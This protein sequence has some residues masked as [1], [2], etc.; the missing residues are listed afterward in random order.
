MAE[1][2]LIPRIRSVLR[3]RHYSRRTEEAYV[4]WIKR[5]IF[6][7]NKRHPASMGGDE[8]NQ[9][10]TS[11]AVDGGVSA[12]TQGQALSALLF[13]YRYV[14]ED[15][16]PWLDDVVRAHRPFRIPVV[17]TPDE[18]RRLLE[19]LAGVPKLIALLLYGGGLRL[20]EC[21]RLR[22]KDVNFDRHE[23]YVRDPKGRRDRVTT[24]PRAAHQLL[25]EHLL[26]VHQVHQR[27]LSRGYGSVVLPGAL[28]RK[29]P[30]AA[31]DWHWQWVFPARTRWREEPSG[32]ERHH[33]VHETVMQRAIKI[34]ATAANF[35]KRVTCHTLRHSSARARPGHPH[36]P[37]APR[38]PRR[39]HD[40]DLHARSQNR[41]ERSAEPIGRSMTCAVVYVL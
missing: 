14:L 35:D 17:L 30:S 41:S 8:V 27:D 32:I 19:H 16:L 11:L 10:L 29:L 39:H 24:F 36:R 18:V 9:F 26:R 5:Y 13:L 4:G 31:T 7:H 37:G 34:A 38:P 28:A 1:Q 3:A 23:L 20:L 33:H 25:R 40:H 15:P 21:L 12:A 22:V 2:R 6:F